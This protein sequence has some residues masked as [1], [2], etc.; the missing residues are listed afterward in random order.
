MDK[1]FG[2]PELATGL[3]LN[4]VRYNIGG[5]DLAARDAHFLRPGGFVQ[6]YLPKPADTSAPAAYDWTADATQRRVLAAA[7]QRGV[8]FVQAF[9]NS[10]PW[11][12]TVSGSVTGSKTGKTD[13]LRADQFDAFA[14]YLA[15]V[16]QQFH[17]VWNVTF[18]SVTPLNEPVAD[19]WK[20]GNQQE[21]CHFD[22]SSQSRIVGLTGKALQTL[23][24]PIG[25]SAAEENW[26]DDTLSSTSAYSKDD[27]DQVTVVTT[28]TYNGRPGQRQALSKFAASH[29][30]RLWASEYGDGDTSGLT[31]AKRITLDLNEG[32]FSVWTLWQVADLDNSLTVSSGWGLTAAAYCGCD[33]GADCECRPPPPQCIGEK[34]S[35]KPTWSHDPHAACQQWSVNSQWGALKDGETLVEACQSDFAKGSCALTCCE[36]IPPGSGRTSKEGYAGADGTVGAFAIR[37]SFHAYR[38]FTAHIRPGSTIIAPRRSSQNQTVE[39]E[40]SLLAA[41]DPRGRPVLVY[42]NDQPASVR[43]ALPLA[44]VPSALLQEEQDREQVLC[45]AVHVTSET[46]DSQRIGEERLVKLQGAWKHNNGDDGEATPQSQ[47]THELQTVLLPR[48]VTTFVVD[49][50]ST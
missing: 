29:G 1:F 11:W 37:K 43:I 48:S 14:A 7:K 42:T 15:R 18:D 3:G 33:H 40:P 8:Q 22:R 20:F 36:A 32:N 16:C 23:G 44:G 13:N 5:S 9:A 34:D 27:L 39:N 49:V 47:P 46:H 45:A 30:K 41:L 2:D 10:P 35:W 25:V 24:L 19:W 12:M 50:C 17:S 4:Q 21:G 6:A 28:H 26:V 31:L 38:Q